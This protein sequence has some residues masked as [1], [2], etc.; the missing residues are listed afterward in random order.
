[1][2]WPAIKRKFTQEEFRLYVPGLAWGPWRPDKVVLHNTAA[3]SWA[4]WEEK[5]ALDRE[6]GR[7]PGT[8][9]I[10]SL[11]NYFKNDR[12]W[13]GCPHLFIPDDGIWVMNPLTLP[14]VHTP[15][16]NHNSIGIEMVAD[17]S[18]EDDDSGPGLKVKLN[19]VF[20]VAI[21]CETFG[22]SANK[23]TIKLHKDDPKTTHDCPGRDFAQ[24]YELVI[25]AVQDLMGGG[26]LD[27]DEMAHLVTMPDI[28]K[29][30]RFGVSAV[31]GLNFRS[32]PGV[33]NHSKGELAAGV[34]LE[35]L[36]EAPN[37]TMKWL[38]VKTP[39]GYIG[40]VAGKY[41]NEEKGK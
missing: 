40:W 19:T 3:P 33:S 34:R 6:A 28:F 26:E 20:A 4:Q 7:V 10:N 24:D 8:T 14:G 13:S 31:N 27:H 29:P 32:G 35:I 22:L 36:D 23:N 30:I 17:F 15:S 2:A 5:A 41:V 39:A 37:G 25:R 1:M 16:W 21:L 9:R 12:G 11:E 38:Q 18:R